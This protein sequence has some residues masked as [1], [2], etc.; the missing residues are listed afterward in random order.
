MV[1]SPLGWRG[2]FEGVVASLTTGLRV[3]APPEPVGRV[4][5]LPRRTT[6]AVAPRASRTVPSY[7]VR[8]GAA[9]LAALPW[10]WQEVGFEIEFLP[11]RG[12]FLGLT[13]ARTRTISIFVRRGQSEGDLRTTIAHE[14]GHALDAVTGTEEM[15]RSYREVRGIG[16]DVAWYPCERCD[17]LR[18]PAGD[19]AETFARWLVGPGHVRRTLASA[20][21]AEQLSVLSYF[22][23]PLSTRQG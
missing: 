22:F 17:D 10:P 5:A 6:E 14:I 2:G 3:P 1:P 7:A 15:R 8:R 20:P 23:E 16:A 13:D 11:Y 9:A 19:F 12:R 18:S 4:A 21:D